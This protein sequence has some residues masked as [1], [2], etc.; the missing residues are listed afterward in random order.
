VAGARKPVQWFI[1][2]CHYAAGF[3]IFLRMSRP[4]LRLL[5]PVYRM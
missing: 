4:E 3:H 2:I 1:P 5:E